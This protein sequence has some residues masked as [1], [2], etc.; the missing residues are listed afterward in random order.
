MFVTDAAPIVFIVDDDPSI[1]KAFGRLLR[2]LGFQVVTF[3]SAQEFLEHE[4][5][6]APGCLVLDVRMPGLDGLELQR[7]LSEAN[8]TLPIVFITG[9]GDIPMTV[10]AI[11]PAP[12]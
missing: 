6:D 9:H 10:P 3:P 12:A 2:S 7:S 8:V 4:L 1:R 5:P 11:T